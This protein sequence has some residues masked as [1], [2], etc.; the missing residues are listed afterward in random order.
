MIH[1]IL[2]FGGS[3]DPPHLGHLN[4][5]LTIQ[6]HIQLER[7]IF[8][9]CKAPILKKITI[10]SCEQRIHMLKLALESHSQFEIDL[11]EIHRKTPSYMVNTLKSFRDEL[12]NN[13]S[14]TLLI[15]MDA[16]LQLPQWHAWQELLD[17]SHILVMKR[18]QIDTQVMPKQVSALLNSN[19]VFDK[20]E[21]LTKPYG[22]IYQYNAGE[23]AISSTALRQKINAGEDVRLYLPEAVYQYLIKKKIYM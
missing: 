20:A 23:Y 4:T 16:F 1:N 3:F 2:I 14:I 13:I 11:R 19:E 15:G 17:L 12:G 21:L 8:L 10:A 22:K 18:A 5:A 9:P 6:N 7:F